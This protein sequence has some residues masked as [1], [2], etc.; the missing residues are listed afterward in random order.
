MRIA[1]EL[2]SGKA[3]SK[4]E[5]NALTNQMQ[6]AFNTR[7]REMQNIINAKTTEFSTY[8]QQANKIVRNGATREA[9]QRNR[10]TALESN[11]NKWQAE[12]NLAKQRLNVKNANLLKK[13]EQ[14]KKTQSN[15]A[16]LQKELNNTKS[17]SAAEK[18]A[19]KTQLEAEKQNLARQFTQTQ[20]DLKST[21][22]EL[23][24][25]TKNR[26]ILFKELQNRSGTLSQTRSERN[27]LQ[28]QLEDTKKILGNTQNN[29]GQLAL[30][31]Q[32]ARG[33]RNT[34]SS[35][36]AQ[37]RGQRQNLRR[38]NGASQKVITGLT[39][40]RQNAQRG[41]N[42]L[43]AQTR[44]LEQKRLA[45]N[46]ATNNRFNASAAFN[47]QMKGVA[48]RQSRQSLK[49]KATMLG[50]AQLGVGKALREKLLKN[51]DTTNING[52][53]V[54]NGGGGGMIP[55]PG[56]ERRDLKK[57][58]QDPMTGL[59]RLRAIEKMILKRKTNRN[60]TILQRRRMNKVLSKQG[61][62]VNIGRSKLRGFAASGL[63]QKT[64]SDVT[65]RL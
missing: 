5:I 65:R 7:Q 60:T 25:L 14:I 19:I 52:K 28:K 33:Q 27:K 53:L 57:V 50:A 11:R 8:R 42:A 34:L 20:T 35:K 15:L 58:V 22:S 9:T 6:K 39:R 63:N 37:V 47:R 4:A 61:T 2:E 32:R 51:V 17:A 16:R 10:I 29:L 41:I 1:A 45:A 24:K 54:V 21:E 43:R 3:K 55:L 44:N 18:N 36:L 31:E 13:I 12:F 40:Q 26:N 23:I 64:I 30:A 46:R 59:N 62:S 56:G 48:A 49:P 38:R